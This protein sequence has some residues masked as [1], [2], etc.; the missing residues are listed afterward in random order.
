M[1]TILVLAAA[2]ATTLAMAGAA[3]AQELECINGYRMVKDQVPVV[4]HEGP[5]GAGF[6]ASAPDR[7]FSE[8]AAPNT[9]NSEELLLGE[10]ESGTVIEEPA[11]EEP[12]Y[13]GSIGATPDVQTG[14]ASE[15]PD[16]SDWRFVES[17]EQCEPGRYWM[18]ELES[19]NRP[20]A[21]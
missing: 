11:I 6:F 5:R 18:L 10:A 13:T 20:M 17:R 8:E 4:C 3:S 15:L 16:S 12:L 14:N 1:K 9:G 7:D 21:C 2:A 19:G